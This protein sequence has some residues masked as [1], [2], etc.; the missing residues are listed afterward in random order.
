VSTAAKVAVGYVKTEG[1][2]IN[3]LGGKKG[4]GY[5]MIGQYDL[6]KRTALYGGWMATT[7]ETAAGVETAKTT[8]FAAGV[9][10]KF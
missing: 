4:A 3:G 9:R 1:D 6:S 10:H 5:S 2:V 7:A 8:T